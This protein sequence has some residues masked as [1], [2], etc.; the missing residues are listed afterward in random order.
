MKV[1]VL[2]KS[3]SGVP[4]PLLTITDF[5]NIETPLNKRK[6]IVITSRIHP[7]ES[8]SSWMMEGFLRQLLTDDIKIKNILKLFIFK[9]IPMLNPDGVIIGNYRTSLSGTD[10]N[11]KFQDP[12]QFLYP[13]IHHLKSLVRNILYKRN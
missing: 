4:I 8:N 12:N 3:L 13:S 9:V 10:L 6:I 1:G 7:G 11:R 2:T 5:Q